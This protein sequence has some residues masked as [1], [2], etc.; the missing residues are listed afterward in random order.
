MPG[1]EL[2]DVAEELSVRSSSGVLCAVSNTARANSDAPECASQ[3]GA[4]RAFFEVSLHPVPTPPG[5]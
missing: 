2:Q 1:P 5:R 4:Q 3:R